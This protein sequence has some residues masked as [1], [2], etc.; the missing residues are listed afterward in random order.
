MK[1][2]ERKK[3]DKEWSLK[4]RTR[5]NFICQA[6]GRKA[7][8]N[9]AA[10]IIPKHDSPDLRYN[11]RNGITLCYRCHVVGPKSCHQ[12]PLWFNHWL[13]NYNKS[14]WKWAMIKGGIK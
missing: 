13:K 11:V 4:V 1:L 14:L 8:N 6:C 12:N 2:K 9:N 10:H 5:D 3:L 7:H